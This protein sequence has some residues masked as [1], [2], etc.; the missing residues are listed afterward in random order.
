MISYQFLTHSFA[1]LCHLAEWDFL[2]MYLSYVFLIRKVI[3][4]PDVSPFPVLIFRILGSVFNSF[5]SAEII[6]V[7]SY[8]LSS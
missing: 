3:L 1:D 7:I 2:K 4:F 8:I 5:N 6:V